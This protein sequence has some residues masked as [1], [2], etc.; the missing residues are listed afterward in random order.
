MFKDALPSDSVGL[1]FW[2]VYTRWHSEVLKILKPL[3]INHTQFVIL[4][5][6]LWCKE[7]QKRSTQAEIV[8]ITGLD[9]MALSKSLKSLVSRA[10]IMKD[11]N[12]L[13]SRSFLLKLSPNGEVLTKTALML[14][15]Q[16]DQQY[17]S[18]LKHRKT[19]FISLLQE[20]RDE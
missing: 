19:L 14:I 9:K 15:E 4:A 7:N 6:I 8:C 20:I 18:R 16:L 11:K 1:Q 10:L 5:S 3:N 12:I 2:T 17:F 13:D